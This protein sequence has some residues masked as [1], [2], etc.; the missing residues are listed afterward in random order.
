MYRVRYLPQEVPLRRNQHHQL[1]HQPRD[2][3]LAPIQRQQF[4]AAPS[5]HAESRPGVGSGGNQRYWQEYSIE[6]VGGQA[7]AQL[8]P[9]REPTGLGG[10]SEVLQRV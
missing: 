3:G 4:Q 9:L 10:D 7:E 6:G 8:G 2:A 1:A 5:A